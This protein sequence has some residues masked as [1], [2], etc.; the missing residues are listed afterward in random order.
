MI[1]RKSKHV[2]FY[3]TGRDKSLLLI[4]RR[5]ILEYEKYIR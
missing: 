2:C 5:Y 3:T 4:E 1:D